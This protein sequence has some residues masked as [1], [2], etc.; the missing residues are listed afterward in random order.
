MPVTIEWNDNAKVAAYWPEAQ[1]ISQPVSITNTGNNPLSVSLEAWTNQTGLHTTFGNNDITLEP[2]VKKDIP[3]EVLVEP[4]ISAIDQTV[5]AIAVKDKQGNYLSKSFKVQAVCGEQPAD[6]QVYFSPSPSILGG[7]NVASTGMGA[8]LLL[9]KNKGHNSALDLFDAMTP[10]T[11]G[12]KLS[13][14]KKKKTPD[15]TIKL[16]GDSPVPVAGFA[17]NPLSRCDSEQWVK[18]FEIAL[19]SDG[20][21]FTK[22]LSEAL[23]RVPEEQ[24]YTLNTPVKATHAQL[25]MV[26][27]HQ[28][29][30]K[31]LC[32]GEWKVIASPEHSFNPQG[33]NIALPELGGHIAWRTFTA[34]DSVTGQLL[35]GT[36]YKNKAYMVSDLPNEWVIGFQHNRMARISRLEWQ[37]SKEKLIRS[38]KKVRLAVSRDGAAGPWESIGEWNFNKKD[39]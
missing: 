17:L 14:N 9:E 11:G 23:S 29:K 36:S 21:I 24:Y 3:F 38:L 10:I 20:K 19:S 12:V 22:V 13:V 25:K 8:T 34:S 33:I 5:V 18:D 39:E 2:G 26:N 7:L 27:N 4:D 30:A 37:A 6:P 28:N 35:A 31:Q 15:I 1:R 32:L 16:A